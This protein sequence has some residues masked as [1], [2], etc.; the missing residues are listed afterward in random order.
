MQR[1]LVQ[2][3]MCVMQRRT[4]NMQRTLMQ[5]ATD[6]FNMQRRM[7]NMQRTMMQHATDNFNMQR[8]MCNM[9]RTLMQHATRNVQHGEG[10]IG[11]IATSRSRTR[12][13]RRTCSAAPLRSS[14]ATSPACATA[15]VPAH[16]RPIPEYP[17]VPGVPSLTLSSP[18]RRTNWAVR[19]QEEGYVT[20][21]P[22]GNMPAY[23]APEARAAG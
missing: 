15:Y 17:I 9:Y 11:T 4:C 23:H 22:V 21:P 1:T 16:P 19:W 13:W 20:N 14:S 5:H 8:R 3:A 10:S 7:C 2:Q 18:H 12:W 6:N